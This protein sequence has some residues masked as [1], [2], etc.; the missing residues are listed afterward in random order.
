MKLRIENQQIRFRLSDDDLRLFEQQGHLTTTLH[1]ANTTSWSYTLESTNNRRP[2][3]EAVNQNLK[4]MLPGDQLKAWMNSHE[5]EWHFE[6]ENLS[7]DIEKDLK[8][9][10]GHK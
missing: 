9:Q 2:H 8:K 5:I 1:L 4:V 3:V 10:G 7:V 6:S